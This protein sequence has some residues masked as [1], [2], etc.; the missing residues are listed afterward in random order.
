MA[1]RLAAE[2]S[3]YLLQHKDNPVD[4]FAW[5]EEAL[6]RAKAEDK[7]ILV[8]IGY[9]ACH[10]CH[11]MEHESFEDPE[12]AAYMN[13]HFVSVKVDREERP[14]VDAIYMQA[15]QAM[16]GH[17]GWPLNA[18]VDPEG[19]PFFGG[20]YFPPESRQGMPSFRQVLEGV[21]EAWI[22]KR[23]EIRAAAPKTVERLAAASRVRP[24]DATLSP[25]LLEE[26]EHTLA[27][28][29]DPANGGFG[30]APKF[31]P[32]SALEFLMVRGSEGALSIATTLERMARGGIYD[33]VGGGFARYSVDAHWLVPHFE[34][35]LY[36][37]ALLARAYLHAWQLT[38]NERFRRVC[39]ETLDWALREM[40]GPEG[41]FYSALDAD[42][43]GEEGKFYVWSADELR[44]LLGDDAE[45]LLRYWGADRGP[46]FEGHSILHVAGEEID[47]EVLARAR[48]KLYA[49]RSER[50]WPGL[51]D[52]RITAW[53]ALMIAALAD[54]GAALERDDYLDAARA[55]A[56]FIDRD[57]RDEDGR[58]LRTYKDGRASLNAYLEDHAFLVEALLVL[59]EATFETPRFVRA[60]ELADSMIERYHDEGGTGFFTTSRDHQALVVRPKDFEDHP[61]PS[62][63]S[64]AAYGLLRLSAFTGAREYEQRALEVFQLLHEAAARHA[65]A[66]GHLLQALQFYFSPRREVALVGEPVDTL[67][68]VVRRRYHPTIVLAGMAPGD[69]EAEAAIPLLA[70]RT[71]VDGKPAAYVCENFACNLPVS[72]P[73]ELERQLG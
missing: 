54:A 50:T 64:S 53:N 3:P 35:M 70:G 23:E 36:D 66:F 55:C 15:V 37:N 44:E 47:P 42:S 49:V 33:Q 14:D 9:S 4:W 1:N 24:S 51:D 72:D 34:K 16:T 73:E 68:R 61:I 29:F 43:E 19:V 71:P 7:P 5:G 45:A 11:V 20:T 46:N 62:G 59:Y 31:P 67:A 22:T 58:L 21:S 27:S 10:W 65:P 28:Q 39:E 38:G 17:G 63:N 32:A 60:R 69:A 26:A 25:D 41:G 40:R 56:D 2:T 13:E 57:M 6:A 18:F 30:G 12:T 52:K 48:D 8:S